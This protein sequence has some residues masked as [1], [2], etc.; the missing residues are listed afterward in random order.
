ML[1][2]VLLEVKRVGGQLTCG[3]VARCSVGIPGAGS[4]FLRVCEIT[5]HSGD[6][7]RDSV[8]ANGAVGDLWCC[9]CLAIRS[10]SV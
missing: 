6:V 10:L 7:L 9:C 8:L 5:S 3:I 4:F 2:G 1:A